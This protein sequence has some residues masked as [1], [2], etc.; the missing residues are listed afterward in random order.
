MDIQRP[1]ARTDSTPTEPRTAPTNVS[2]SC[3]RVELEPAVD[4]I[5][6]DVE[7]NTEV[8]IDDVDVEMVS[9]IEGTYEVIDQRPYSSSVKKVE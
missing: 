4:D 8:G 2:T 6:A 5:R 7:M 9:M 3:F 1:S